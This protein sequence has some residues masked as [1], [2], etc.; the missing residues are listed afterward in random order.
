M[1]LVNKDM[2][3]SVHYELKVDNNGELVT[4]D[5]SKPEQPLVYLHGAGMLLADFES[6][7]AG[8]TVGDTV[9]FVVSAENGYGV[10]NEQ[11]IVSVPLD[12]FKDA[13]GNVDTNVIKV[14]NVLPMMDNQGNQFQGIV[15][16]ITP[17]AVI[18]D[19]NHPMAGKELNFTVTVAEVR[20]ATAEE[21]AHGHVHG[22]GGHH[23]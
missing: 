4:A 20:P 13:E 5:K 22:P 18:M 14:G 19:F 12:S 15:C 16:E 6:N 17:E 23:H 9:S 21:L 10:R 11:D 2:V 3:V 7:L 1:L 8:K